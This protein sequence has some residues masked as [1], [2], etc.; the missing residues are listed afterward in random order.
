MENLMLRLAMH[1]PFTL[2]DAFNMNKD[3]L[4]YPGTYQ[5]AIITLVDMKHMYAMEMIKRFGHGI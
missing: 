1:S 2:Q 5:D 3:A 4:G